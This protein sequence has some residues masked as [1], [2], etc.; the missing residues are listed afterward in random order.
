MKQWGGGIPPW[1]FPSVTVT[2]A[3]I[4]SG[5][6]IARASAGTADI[7]T[8]DAY[9]SAGDLVENPAL[10]NVPLVISAQQVDYN[11]PGLSA[12]THVRLNGPVLAEIYRGQITRW[13]DPA[14]AGLNPGVRLADIPIVPVH[15]SD[16]SGDTFLFSSYL[17]TQDPAWNNAFGYGTTVAWPLVGRA[18]AAMGNSGMVSACKATPGCVAYVG[19]SY[20]AQARQDGLGEAQLENAAG[21]F[22]SPTPAAIGAAVANFVSLTPPNETISMVDGPASG[23]YPIVNYEYAIVNTRQPDAT[24]ARAIR[25]FLRWL[26][27]KGNSGTYVDPWGFRALPSPVVALAD[28]QINQIR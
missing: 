19:I 26:I 1:Q 28:T 7:G 20:H 9:L 27:H 22:V 13:N 10:V 8:S 14:I 12:G 16:S 23:G 25:T 21:Q 17:S 5:K 15:R 18:I 24:R 4:G 11:I 6:G 2:T 3:A